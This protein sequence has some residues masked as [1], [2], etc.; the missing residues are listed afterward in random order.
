MTPA[1]LYR[2]MT[3]FS[4]SYPVGSFSYSHGLETAVADGA[5]A[6]RETLVAWVVAAL[7]HGPGMTDAVLF[8][9]AWTATAEVDDG[10]LED[11]V[12]LGRVL[13]PTAELRLQT[14][15]QGRAFLDATREAWPCAALKALDGE[16]IPLPVAAGAVCAGHDVPLEEGLSAFLTEYA[17]NLVSAGL[18][19]IPLGQRDGQRAIAA[20]EPVIADTV[21]ASAGPT[22]E[23]V[24]GAA[25]VI[26][27]AGM[28]HETQYTRLFRS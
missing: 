12:R 22:L 19:L 17:A 10:A 2:L 15:S 3:W 26:D 25:P 18:R 16:D 28:R 1:A 4:P 8:R 24:G 13:T 5:V 21:S 6:D 14:L 20:L 27:L 23:T 9:A 11:A 7:R